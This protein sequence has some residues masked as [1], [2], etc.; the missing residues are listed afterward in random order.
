MKEIYQEMSDRIENGYILKM[1]N[2]NALTSKKHLFILLELWV[3]R[4]EKSN[5]TIGNLN[6]YNNNVKIIKLNLDINSYYI[7]ADTT[8]EGV[9][10]FL[11]NK[12]TKWETIENR[13]GNRNK[14][15]NTTNND[16]ISGFYM[17][18]VIN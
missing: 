13:N 12:K 11:E 8:R 15:T 9:L 1:N 10:K 17:Y 2:E 5:D 14:V 16:P 7:D 6:I 3:K 18:K 4:T